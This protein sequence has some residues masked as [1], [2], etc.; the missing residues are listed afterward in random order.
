MGGH[1][2]G[3]GKIF[4][5]N[6]PPGG[7]IDHVFESWAGP[8]DWLNGWTYDSI[9]NLRQLNLLE[10]GINTFTNPLNVAIAAPLA[11]PLALP[12]EAAAAPGIIYGNQKE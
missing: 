5:F 10:T 1:E 6:Y 2:G 4:G 9:G 8:H 12:R 11:I 3:K 7:V